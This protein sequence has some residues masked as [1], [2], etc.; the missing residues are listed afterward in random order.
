MLPQIRRA[1]CQRLNLTSGDSP[2][3]TDQLIN[4]ELQILEEDAGRHL[5]DERSL[6]ALQLPML[7]Q[8]ADTY[9][10]V[11][12]V[13]LIGQVTPPLPPAL[14]QRVKVIEP[15]L[16]YDDSVWHNEAYAFARWK[17]RQSLLGI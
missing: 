6:N 17:R 2:K 9:R 7:G 11:T 4:Q 13:A 12:F 15:P 16:V 1:L 3:L 10:R 8:L 14:Q 5:V